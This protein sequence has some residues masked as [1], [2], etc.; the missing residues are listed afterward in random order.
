MNQATQAATRFWKDYSLGFL[1]SWQWTMS[2]TSGT[3]VTAVIATLMT[4]TSSRSW[5]IIKFFIHQSRRHDIQR[6]A[7]IREQEVYLRVAETDLGTFWQMISLHRNWDSIGS[8]LSDGTL[9]SLFQSSR[10]STW[11]ILVLALVHFLTWTFLAIRMPEF[12]VTQ[13]PLILI[14][15]DKCALW[16]YDPMDPD[17]ELQNAI[18]S[19]RS[20]QATGAL[21]YY[22]NCYRN[23]SFM[24]PAQCAYLAKAV[25][26][27]KEHS[28]GCLF[29]ESVCLG[30]GNQSIVFDTGELKA[31]EFG[32]NSPAQ[33]TITI[34]KKLTCAPLNWTKFYVPVPNATFVAFNFTGS[35][36]TKTSNRDYF[37]LFYSNTHDDDYV[38]RKVH[39]A[40][41]AGLKGT[42]RT[43]LSPLL[44]TTDGVVSIFIIEKSEVLFV[45]PVDDLVFAAH[46]PLDQLEA[47]MQLY[48]ADERFGIIG[49]KDQIQIYNKRNGLRSSWQSLDLEHIIWR[50][51]INADKDQWQIIQYLL[52]SLKNSGL[53]QFPD[54]WGASR[55]L[56][57]KSSSIV[58]RV[59]MKMGQEHWKEEARRWLGISLARAQLNSL[60]AAIGPLYHEETE[61]F[62]NAL[63]SPELAAVKD[64]FCHSMKVHS[65]AHVSI[66]LSKL[67]A[68][69][70]FIS[71][72]W[73]LSLCD[74]YFARY[75][76]RKRPHAV[77]AWYLDNPTQLLRQ[78][79][80]LLYT[81][82]PR[83]GS[84]ELAFRT[85]GV[86]C[87]KR[88]NGSELQAYYEPL[89]TGHSTTFNDLAQSLGGKVTCVNDF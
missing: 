50:L 52:A 37:P 44:R 46:R 57:A 32:I 15:S 68:F 83:S 85:L 70:L 9:K 79:H 35:F 81:R 62:T 82:S 65:L 27:W 19:H 89:S 24:E 7:M 29:D 60:E 66:T 69:T 64:F 10:R 53:A 41:W 74:G 61:P 31:E 84:A 23:S 22:D 14:D 1:G 3:A 80:E 87:L 49:C 39:H 73:F 6:N 18:A 26:P 21:Q 13:N 86:P 33:S 55:I 77:L 17:L 20:S 30:S 63:D 11:R 51:G 28:E 12:L 43:E 5:K 78:L 67:L 71:L 76:F 34:Q 47:G 59:Q 45:E 8:L 42:N 16:E 48:E 54:G 58:R 25:L 56:K 2:T 38:I 75:M 72:I 36:A 4:L 40:G 88:V